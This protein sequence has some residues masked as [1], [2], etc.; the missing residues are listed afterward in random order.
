MAESVNIRGYRIIVCGGR[1]YEDMGS[2]FI[3]LDSLPHPEH[4]LLMHGAATGAD[5]LAQK[6]AILRDARVKSYPAN[7]GDLEHDDAIIKKTPSGR[8]YD[9]NA[10][11]RRNEEMLKELPD[12]VIAFPGGNG[13]A[14]M[15]QIALDAMVPVYRFRPED[16]MANIHLL[17]SMFDPWG[18]VGARISR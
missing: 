3:V 18:I 2:V 4:L 11:R 14:H 12:L 7:W 13:T 1:K 16:G 6:W 10:G 5:S 15:V 9:V 8:Y 17:T